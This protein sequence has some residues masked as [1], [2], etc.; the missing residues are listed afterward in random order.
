MRASRVR[1]SM[2]FPLGVDPAAARSALSGLAGLPDRMEL[3]FE[4]AITSEG[5][6]HYLVVP[7]AVRAS[8]VSTMTGALPGLRLAEAP[9]PAGRAS[10]SLRVFVPTPTVLV[11]ET[12]QATLAAFGRSGSAAR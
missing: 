12:P 1:L 3:V 10:L 7:S 9:E 8:V 5:V 6:S 11:S 4:T 2:R